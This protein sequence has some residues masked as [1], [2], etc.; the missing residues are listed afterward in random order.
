MQTTIRRT[1]RLSGRL[2]FGARMR[3]AVVGLTIAALTVSAAIT[4]GS[5]VY[6]ADYPSWN[7]VIAARSNAA[8][9]QD[10]VNQLQSLISGLQ[11]EVDAAQAAADKA[12]A[13]NQ[14]AQDALNAG[15]QKAD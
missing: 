8:S 13:E 7:D 12:W 5:P 9:T 4:G 6:A 10:E 1:P 14:A 15:K 11:S 2:R 3:I